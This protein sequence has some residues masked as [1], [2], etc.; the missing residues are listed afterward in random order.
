MSL[1]SVLARISEIQSA[2]APPAAPAAGSQGSFSS[3]LQSAMGGTAPATDAGAPV[4]GGAA[5]PAGVQAK[6][7]PGSYPHLSGDLDASPEMLQRLEALAA[8]K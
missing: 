2:M 1:H 6:A 7:A 4:G 8:K 3:Q 5:G